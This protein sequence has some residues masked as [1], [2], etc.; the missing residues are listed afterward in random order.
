MVDLHIHS[1][2]SDGSKT[3]REILVEA[4]DLGLN[5]ISFTD[6]E[7]C[8]AYNELEK[9]NIKD[10]Y[11]GNIINGIELKSKY[12]E[13]VMDILGYGINY[14]KIKKY[15]EEC[16]KN[17]T[18]EK[19]QESQ[20]LEFYELGLKNK[21]TL[22]PIH[23]LNW[24]RT[25]DWA[26]IVF[27][28]E[29]KSHLENK[30]KVP[31]DLWEDFKNFKN[32]HYHIKGDPFYINMT[33]DYPKIEKIIDIIHK[34]GGKA[35]IAHIYQYKEIDDKIL[36]LKE[37]ISKYSIDGIECYHSSFSNT[38]SEKLLKFAKSHN[39]LISGGSDYHGLNKPDISLGCGK[40]NLEIP[41][42]ILIDWNL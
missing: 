5:T 19:I 6:H 16:Y 2:Y 20:L 12:K 37:I 34:S 25:K 31:P 27:Y 11:S 42:E 17:I 4:Q 28:N 3:V 29:V 7:T 26:S 9:I 18:R 14:K 21:L 1:T 38:E 41:D 23:E 8:N 39:L 10:Y 15:L 36:E 40:G 35:F 13:I 33:K 24:D 22:R 32:N 30:S